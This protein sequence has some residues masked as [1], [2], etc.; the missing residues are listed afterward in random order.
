MATFAKPIT[1]HCTVK[2]SAVERGARMWCAVQLCRFAQW[3]MP[4]VRITFR[5]H[6]GH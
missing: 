3:I 4:T 1:L 6:E 2:P 5:I